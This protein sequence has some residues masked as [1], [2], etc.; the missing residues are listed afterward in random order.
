MIVYQIRKYDM[1][2]KVLHTFKEI[3]FDDDKSVVFEKPH[4]KTGEIN[5]V[6][7]FING[8][9]ETLSFNGYLNIS[10][11]KNKKGIPDTELFLPYTATVTEDLPAY[12]KFEPKV[13]KHCKLM[14]ETH[15][16]YMQFFHPES[17]TILRIAINSNYY[18]PEL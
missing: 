10:F 2:G 5:F 15:G 7:G 16:S 12:L 18:E 6:E 11:S 14:V 3:N 9:K 4:Y 8:E 1:I 17:K 13:Y